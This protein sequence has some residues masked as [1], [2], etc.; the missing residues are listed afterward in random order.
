VNVTAS[1]I[2][3]ARY[4]VV[5]GLPSSKSAVPTF[6]EWCRF[7]REDLGGQVPSRHLLLA[8]RSLLVDLSP[9]NEED[10]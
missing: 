6:S 1:S 8:S 7:V 4:L 10:L 3:V 9:E 2:L 5:R